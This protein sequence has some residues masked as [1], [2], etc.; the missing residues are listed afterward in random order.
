M[1]SIKAFLASQIVL[2]DEDAPRDYAMLLGSLAL[3]VA[4][5]VTLLDV[6]GVSSMA[7]RMMAL[8]AGG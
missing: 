5:A 3:V 2:D 7:S 6:G 1:S 8:L 4:S